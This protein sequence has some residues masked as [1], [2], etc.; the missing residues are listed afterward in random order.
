VAWLSGAVDTR[1]PVPAC[2]AITAVL[3]QYTPRML[4]RHRRRMAQAREVTDTVR[5]RLARSDDPDL[6]VIDRRA[7]LIGAYTR[8]FLGHPQDGYSEFWDFEPGNDPVAVRAFAEMA[9]EQAQ[10]P[11]WL[12]QLGT[13]GLLGMRAHALVGDDPQLQ[14]IAYDDSIERHLPER[15]ALPVRVMVQ[16]TRP[17]AGTRERERS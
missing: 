4:I 7:R 17:G 13:A 12:N 16:L 2:G 11:G 9:A 6:L 3:G 5:A 14:R 15:P 10:R 1:L 8:M